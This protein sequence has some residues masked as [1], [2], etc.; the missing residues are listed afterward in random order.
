LGRHFLEIV[1]PEDRPLSIQLFHRFREESKSLIYEQR[2]ITKTG[3]YRL[4][5]FTSTS[6][7]LNGRIVS[8]SGIARD[9]TERRKLEEELRKSEERYRTLVETSPDSIALTDIRG[10]IL[11]V[12]Q[13]AVKLFGYEDPDELIGRNVLDL[14]VPEDRTR[15][16]ES[17]R[18][19][20]GSGTVRNAEYRMTKKG[21]TTFMAELSAS[22][23]LD[24]E[25]KPIAFMGVTRDIS[26]RKRALEVLRTSEERY[27]AI[28]EATGT[29]MCTVGKDTTITFVNGEFERITGY[30]ASDIEGVKRLLDFIVPEDVANFSNY[31]RK[32]LE[33]RR[34]VK[35]HFGCRIA[36]RYRDVLFVLVS[37]GLLPGTENC[38]VSLIDITREKSYERTLEERA[39][40]LRNF[41]DIASHELRHPITIIKGYVQLLGEIIKDAPIES[42]QNILDAIDAST[43]RLDRLGDELLD[44]SRIESNQFEPKRRELDLK[45]LAKQAIDEMRARG[46]DN[47]FEIRVDDRA[48]YVQADEEKI[49]RLLVILLENAV[50]FSPPS[51]PIEIVTEGGAGEIMVSIL[52]RGPGI[53]PGAEEKIFDR[54]F[55]VEDVLHHSKPGLGLGLFIA[56]EIAEAH[57]GNIWYEPR[58][59]GGSI[60]RFTLPA[61]TG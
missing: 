59:D 5:E 52:D 53:P 8:F 55:Q 23:V 39:Q 29:A 36:N 49:T 46:N 17:M 37:M 35:K 33:G 30:A 1:H 4:L 13:Q 32:I 26:E 54:F 16:L 20:S 21:G 56:R 25:G 48:R 40:Q 58:P 3:D 60:F 14:F 6:E 27:R 50:K 38:V 19:K 61:S 44:V 7:V 18:D 24:A 31:H 45:Q 12:N 41:L 15:A 10:N 28:F 34:D 43:V 9:I 57:S 47:P 2:V 42:V 22:L 51:L 11:M